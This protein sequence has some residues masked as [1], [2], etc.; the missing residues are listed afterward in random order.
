MSSS[1]KIKPGFGSDYYPHED[2]VRLVLARL[3][4]I[5]ATT[6]VSFIIVGAIVSLTQFPPAGQRQEGLGI[7]ETHIL[8]VQFAAAILIAHYVSVLMVQ[9]FAPPAVNR[10]RL[11][12]NTM[13]SLLVLTLCVS[14]SVV[15]HL[16]PVQALPYLKPAFEIA[17]QPTFVI[18]NLLLCGI[19]GLTIYWSRETR[20]ADMVEIYWSLGLMFLLSLS[21]ALVMAVVSI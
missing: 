19:T 4:R 9:I 12:S 2:N 1:M 11:A 10:A 13:F 6:I 14:V 3:F 20:L 15:A 17:F 18:A 16:V 21:T 7:H 8:S 5:A